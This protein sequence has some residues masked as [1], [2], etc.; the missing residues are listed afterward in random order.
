MD[1]FDYFEHKRA[2]FK[3][4]S[5]GQ[6]T[7]SDVDHRIAFVAT[8]DNRGFVD[9]PF[10]LDEGAYVSVFERVRI[11]DRRYARRLRY[12][13]YLIIDGVGEKRGY[14]L[15]PTHSPALHRHLEDHSKESWPAV[16][17]RE[18]VEDFWDVLTQH[19][20]GEAGLN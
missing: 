16:S 17:L 8:G 1:I 6:M 12:S 2:D 9:G 3:R 5:S 19:R 18:A 20:E 11:V 10:P 15:D 13:Y 4:F 7:D 14:E